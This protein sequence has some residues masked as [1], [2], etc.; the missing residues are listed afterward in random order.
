MG[1]LF[2]PATSR[3]T[4]RPHQVQAI[5]ML[6][7]SLGR[8]NRRT[9]LQ[10]GTGFGK[11]LTAA[12]IIRSALDK[13]RRVVFTVPRISLVN[14][15]LEEFEGEGISDIGVIQANH[16][17]HNPFARVQIASLA[18]LRKR[19]FMPECDLVIVDEAHM[20]PGVI[21]DWMRDKPNMP[22]VGL[23]ATPWQQGMG[24]HWQDLVSPI[25]LAE[26][27]DKGFLSPFT[28]Y[29]PSHPDVSKVKIGA[30]G[31][32]QENELS[33]VMQDVRLVADVV[34]T[35]KQRAYGLPTLVFAV[36]LAHAQK[37]QDAFC[38]AGIEMGYVEAR[39]DMAERKMLLDQMESGK[40]SGVV[41]VGTMTTGVDAD[42]RCV[43]LARPTR[44]PIFHVQAIGRALRNAPGKERAIIL[45]HA[46]NHARLGFVTDIHYPEMLKGKAKAEPK[47]H[48]KPERLPRECPSCGTVKPAGICPNCGFEPTRRSDIE[49]EE[50]VLLEIT[51]KQSKPEKATMQDKQKFWSGLLHIAHKRN[52]S[53]GWASHTYRE[54]FGVWPRG[55]QDRPTEPLPEVSSYV[56]AKD[57]RFA[58]RR[59][60]AQ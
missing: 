2:T 27:I 6:R 37:I 53:K 44:S 46:D 51:P 58:K 29:A 15:T 41:S 7:Q 50:G 60:K 32:Y 36:D 54:K 11:T 17:R 30:G 16:H 18:T 40:I 22:F 19:D 26:L 33:E 13:G 49:F 31:D 8:G 35:W 52:R 23:T 28:V 42:V 24:D 1:D 45:D 47:Q 39:T 59:E 10:A 43:V 48:E 9:V 25:S 3:K 56:R 21:Y 14:Q 20:E 34:E 4:L 57:I 5:D 12:T 38:S 55:L